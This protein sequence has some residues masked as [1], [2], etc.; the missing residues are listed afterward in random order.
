MISFRMPD[1]DEYIR[2]GLDMPGRLQLHR[3]LL[4]RVGDSGGPDDY[5]LHGGHQ[6]WNLA[7]GWRPN[8][9]G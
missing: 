7:G 2:G 1:E 4:L 5:S 8:P 3:N 6:G 9:A